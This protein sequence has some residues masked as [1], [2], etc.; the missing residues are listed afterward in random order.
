MTPIA[1]ELPSP[2]AAP[3]SSIAPDFEIDQRE[4][5]AQFFLGNPREILFYLRILAKRR[6]LFTAYLDEGTDFFLDRKSV[7]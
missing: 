7:V 6:S 3:E 4:E 1:E 2:N 5:F